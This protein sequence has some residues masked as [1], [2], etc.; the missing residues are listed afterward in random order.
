MRIFLIFIFMVLLFTAPLYALKPGGEEITGYSE[1]EIIST[2]I[3]EEIDQIEREKKEIMERVAPVR[4]E[5]KKTLHPYVY[6]EEPPDIETTDK[7]IR[8][9]G[10]RL[11]PSTP[12]VS[13]ASAPRRTLVSKVLLNFV[14]FSILAIAL[15]LSYF[16][17]RPRS[18]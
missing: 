7:S 17:I 10:S 13:E 11:T 14:F 16:F 1:E 3:K 6:T 8:F 12:K 2:E 9:K 18:K 5:K 15:F 4:R